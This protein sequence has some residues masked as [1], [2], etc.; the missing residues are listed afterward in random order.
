MTD[1]IEIIATAPWTVEVNGEI[2]ASSDSAPP[3]PQ[4]PDPQ[5]T[6]DW[7]RMSQGHVDNAVAMGPIKYGN[8]GNSSCNYGYKGHALLAPIYAYVGG[9]TRDTVRN[10]INSTIAILTDPKKGPCGMNGPG[11]AQE[12]YALAYFHWLRKSDLW[13]GLSATTKQRI[14]AIFHALAMI[15]AWE[16]NDGSASKGSWTITGMKGTDFRSIGPNIAFAIPAQLVLCAEWFGYDT[17]VSWLNS[18]SIAKVRDEVKAA[19]GGTSSNLYLTVNWRNADISASEE[20]AYFRSGPSS[21]APTDEQ[22]NAAL[23][24]VHYYGAPLT[25]VV[26]FLFPNA[27]RGLNRALPPTKRTMGVNKWVGNNQHALDNGAGVMVGGKKRGYCINNASKAPH[28]P[29]EGSMIYELN[30]QDEGGLR[31][32]MGY[33]WWTAYLVNSMLFAMLLND[34]KAFNDATMTDFVTRWTKAY[35]IIDFFDD[36]VNDYNSVSHI[37]NKGGSGGPGPIVWSTGRADWMPG[38]NQFLWDAINKVAVV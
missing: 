23:S 5:P 28:I 7:P 19:F 21:D 35:D 14:D 34:N 18:T 13:P 29:G 11:A 22:V 32:S 4:P 24:N 31:S 33:A 27:D 3:D 10:S 38:I 37:S 17:L 9:D 1:R 20:G 8:Q 12:C 2:V 26:K 15:R 36:P 16:G 25:D 6:G 30:G